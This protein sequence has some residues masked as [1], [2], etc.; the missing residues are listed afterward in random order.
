[1]IPA[2][3]NPD[4][5]YIDFLKLESE[6]FFKAELQCEQRASWLLTLALGAAV[7]AVS[8]FSGIADGKLSAAAFPF[9]SL[10]TAM[11]FGAMLAA[12]LALWPLSGS[13]GTLH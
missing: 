6:H 12:L 11:L 7:L 8:G 4:K 2:S 13:R 5:D 3:D 10:T 1:M 9:L